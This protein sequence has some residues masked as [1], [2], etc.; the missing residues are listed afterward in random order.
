MAIP[1][2]VEVLRIT[3]LGGFTASW[4][5]QN[6]TF[7]TRREAII[8]VYLF[9]SPHPEHDRLELARL[10]WPGHDVR[11]SRHSLS[12]HLYT[13]RRKL[14]ELE[15]SIST[16]T[17]AC[18][19]DGAWIDV[20]EMRRLHRA[21]RFNAV[22]DLYR[23]PFLHGM[24]P[25]GLRELDAWRDGIEAEV[26]AIARESAVRAI[27]DAIVGRRWQ[28]ARELADR[29]LTRHPHDHIL[30]AY[31]I[32]AVAGTVGPRAAVAEFDSYV[33]GLQRA[34]DPVPDELLEL[35]APHLENWRTGNKW[36]FAVDA[37]GPAIFVGR[38]NEI[39]ILN[40]AWERTR[41][42]D[43]AIVVIEGEPGIGKSTLCERFLRFAALRGARVLLSACR[44]LEESVSYGAIIDALSQGVTA[45]D[46]E[47]LDP[48]W[49]ASIQHAM[50]ELALGRLVPDLP[51]LGNQGAQRRLF[52]AVAQLMA[53][54]SSRQP[55][56]LF[57]DDIQWIDESSAAV[58]AYLARRVQGTRTMLL[59]AIR[60]PMP[61]GSKAGVLAS[62]FRQCGATSVHLGPLSFGECRA[63]IE[64]WERV[65][66]MEFRRF[67]D[68]VL[69]YSAGRPFVISGILDAYRRG[70]DIVSG[71]PAATGYTIRL[72]LGVREYI[73]ETLRTD[74][75]LQESTIAAL[76]VVGR[77]VGVDIIA[78]IVGSRAPEVA[79]QVDHLA[80]RG[81]VRHTQD[82]NVAFAH[83]FI[84]DTA[85]DLVGP[86]LRQQLH[87]AA[88]DAL[89]AGGD[90]P[91][92]I[93]I[94]LAIAGDSPRTYYHA[95]TA[96]DQ[97]ER[98]HAY[99][100]AIRF[101]RL[102]SENAASPRDR[103]QVLLRL[104]RLLTS[105]RKVDEA[106]RVVEELERALSADTGPDDGIEVSALR[107]RVDCYSRRAQPHQLLDELRQLIDRASEGPRR[108]LV[109]EVVDLVPI[110][111]YE[112]GDI[113]AGKRAIGAL[114]RLREL[115]ED[116]RTRAMA[117]MGCALLH[118]F[119]VDGDAAV[120]F[121]REAVAMAAQCKL[122]ELEIASHCTLGDVLVY[123]GELGAAASCYR[124]AES[125]AKQSGALLLLPR[126][127][128]N[129]GI[130][131]VERGD[132]SHALGLFQQASAMRS[133]AMADGH[134]A[135]SL[136]NVYYELGE[137]DAA[138]SWAERATGTSPYVPWW[139]H[140]VAH[141][142]LG[143]CD[144]ERGRLASARQHGKEV[145][146]VLDE[147]GGQVMGDL[148]YPL[149]LLARLES[150][151]NRTGGG[152]AR[153]ERA[154]DAYGNRETCCRLRLQAELARLLARSR[155]ARARDIAL[156]VRE[157][158]LRMGARPLAERAQSVLHRVDGRG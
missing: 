122:P 20:A 33:A 123:V 55:V 34:G 47:R 49:A 124:H 5:D 57:V 140:V 26:D 29:F 113:E 133:S 116:L 22:L 53:A 137:W 98:V 93:V 88:A 119:Y 149:I 59:C 135:L 141:G 61:A 10:L 37:A 125:L 152:V 90:V 71:S 86:S 143:L 9:L 58:L 147:R 76:A 118:A 11:R 112:A 12:Q 23:G 73:R 139:S 14:P 45:G 153:L 54:M 46:V 96:A 19:F 62:A 70:E 126:V 94:H 16:H 148:S 79:K 18:R 130:V 68:R 80:A 87:L 83:E 106:A 128:H 43:G 27:D 64:E 81:L 111:A 42:G 101:L 138:S 8:L 146:R 121:G 72:P 60:S 30:R 39:Q 66:G 92:R 3:T 104:G 74:H 154:I 65:T 151:E 75:P 36:S 25:A 142:F 115:T 107:L 134:A 51:A 52:E 4:N 2:R 129:Q 127:Y 7:G 95:L 32:I 117:V 28:E 144:L 40:R 13:L 156:I 69:Q 114:A 24:I 91:H 157:H 120:R 100:E 85:Y 109:G 103:F 44:V 41:S 15:W 56:I 105:L 21:E 131:A 82:G 158:A 77:P 84:R 78:A 17:V 110:L 155:P 38:R 102:A 99:A 136:A 67:S 145:A 31:R 6:I 50:P 97:S 150:I 132:Y 1:G 35:V 89:L 108:E 48:I 63:F